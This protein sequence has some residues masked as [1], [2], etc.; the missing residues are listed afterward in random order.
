MGI[1]VHNVAIGKTFQAT[2]A[3]QGLPFEDARLT[4]VSQDRYDDVRKWMVM[5]NASKLSPRSTRGRASDISKQEAE[6]IQ[7]L[8]LQKSYW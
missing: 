5:P 7:Q 6:V 3:L 4:A 8:Y 1:W 2:G